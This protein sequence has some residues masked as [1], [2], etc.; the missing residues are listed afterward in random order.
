MNTLNE[1]SRY[2]NGNIEEL[3]GRKDP[4]AVKIVAREMERLFSYEMIKAM[5]E[6]TGISSKNDLGGSTYMSMFDME[7]AKLF[8]ERGLGLQDMLLQGLN[9]IADKSGNQ[10]KDTAAGNQQPLVTG[11]QQLPDSQKPIF[12]AVSYNNPLHP[13]ISSPVEGG[14]VD[15]KNSSKRLRQ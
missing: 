10:D 12:P 4:E 13:A 9:R 5:R 6:T 1:V 11:Q 15:T 7:L 8:S 2:Y 14:E 3:R